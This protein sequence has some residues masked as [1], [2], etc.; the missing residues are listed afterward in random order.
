MICI[1]SGG[2]RNDPNLPTE[3]KYKTKKR[4]DHNG[5]EEHINQ[6]VGGRAGETGGRRTAFGR[7]VRALQHHRQRADD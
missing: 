3:R 5:T 1:L 4:S 2:R 7:A 6:K